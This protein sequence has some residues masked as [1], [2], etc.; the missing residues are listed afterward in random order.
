MSFT[1]FVNSN[2]KEVMK[3]DHMVRPMLLTL[4]PNAAVF[5]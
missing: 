4:W 5:S 1:T 3:N 2:S